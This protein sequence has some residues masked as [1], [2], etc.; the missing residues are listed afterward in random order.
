MSHF[1]K[2]CSG[3]REKEVEVEVCHGPGRCSDARAHDGDMRLTGCLI[4]GGQ[5]S[6]QPFNLLARP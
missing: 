3:D 4:S 2:A 1:G 5:V 6:N